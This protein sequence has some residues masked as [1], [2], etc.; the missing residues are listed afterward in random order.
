MRPQESSRSKNA[1]PGSTNEILR[2]PG[3]DCICSVFFRLS[4]KYRIAERHLLG[5]VG[6]HFRDESA[7][8]G[9]AVVGPQPVD[10]NDRDGVDGAKAE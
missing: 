1:H 9:L 8:P 3:D 10:I 5:D 7:P 4:K 2:I 6:C